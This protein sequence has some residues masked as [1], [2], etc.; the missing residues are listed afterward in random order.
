MQQER[1]TGSTSTLFD[2]HIGNLTSSPNQL[3][4]DMLVK[5]N[6]KMQE[7]ISNKVSELLELQKLRN[8]LRSEQIEL[9]KEIEWLSITLTKTV[10]RHNKTVEKIV[11]LEDLIRLV[12]NVSLKSSKHNSETRPML[13]QKQKDDTTKGHTSDNRLQEKRFRGGFNETLDQRSQFTATYAAVRKKANPWLVNAGIRKQSS[14]N[15]NIPTIDKP[16][17]NNVIQ[18]QKLQTSP[19]SVLMGGVESKHRAEDI[20]LISA[21]PSNMIFIVEDKLAKSRGRAYGTLVNAKESKINIGKG[22]SNGIEQNRKSSQTA[23]SDKSEKKKRKSSNESK[24]KSAHNNISQTNSKNNKKEGEVQTELNKTRSQINERPNTNDSIISSKRNTTDSVKSSSG[25]TKKGKRYDKE[26]RNIDH[27]K[28]EFSLLEEYWGVSLRQ[29][30]LETSF[31]SL[32]IMNS[33]VDNLIEPEAQKPTLSRSVSKKSIKPEKVEEISD[34]QR[35]LKLLIECQECEKQQKDKQY[36]ANKI[37]EQKRKE[38]Y[39]TM[40]RAAGLP[41][42]LP[43]DDWITNDYYC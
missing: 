8:L 30:D 40:R 15:I 31:S 19:N 27:V 22:N 28:S 12:G 5:S 36:E 2:P 39:E 9:A 20:N 3:S 13:E 4:Q 29:S 1:P 41:D 33:I 14:L 43:D 21:A 26:K 6:F 25:S 10:S 17:N 37:A 7:V 11:I 18:K 42:C 32:L 16:P 35:L 24:Q 38:Y 34:F 23:G